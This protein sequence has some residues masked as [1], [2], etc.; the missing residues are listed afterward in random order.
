MSGKKN[1]EID[2]KFIHQHVNDDFE[3]DVEGLRREQISVLKAIKR[4]GERHMKY[5]HETMAAFKFPERRMKAFDT[6]YY[7]RVLPEVNKIL[8]EYNKLQQQKRIR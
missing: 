7:E 3:V 5:F 1:M 8:G 2:S 4:V 6:Q